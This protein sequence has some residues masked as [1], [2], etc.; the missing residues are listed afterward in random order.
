MKDLA[1]YSS[2]S[3]A[4]FGLNMIPTKRSSSIDDLMIHQASES[5]RKLMV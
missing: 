2:P 5:M 4:F 3:H 1:D